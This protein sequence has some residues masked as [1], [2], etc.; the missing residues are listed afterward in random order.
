[1]LWTFLVIMLLISFT[2]NTSD[3]CYIY[4][5]VTNY[6]NLSTTYPQVYTQIKRNNIKYT[7]I[8]EK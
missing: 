2:I 7:K 3:F 5:P 4:K 8:C 1:M 6:K